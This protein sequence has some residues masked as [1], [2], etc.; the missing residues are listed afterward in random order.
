MKDE[1]LTMKEAYAAMFDFLRQVYDQTGSDTIGSL[2][3]S[4]STTGDGKTA[5][6]A[7][8]SD[9]IQ[10]V[11]KAKNSAVNTGLELS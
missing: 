5:D 8:W 10:S 6:P 11:A 3:G 9:W 4:M 1:S 2:L 7:I